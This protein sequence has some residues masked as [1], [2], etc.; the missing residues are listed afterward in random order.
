VSSPALAARPAAFSPGSRPRTRQ[1]RRAHV[2]PVDHG[3]TR[4]AIPGR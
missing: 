4:S 2:R 1:R 3:R